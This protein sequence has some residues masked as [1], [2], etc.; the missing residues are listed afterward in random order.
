MRDTAFRC[1]CG[2]AGWGGMLRPPP[3]RHQASAALSSAGRPGPRRR[4]APHR[5]VLHRASAR[6]T[7]WRGSRPGSGRHADGEL[8]GD[9]R[10]GL[11]PPA[12]LGPAV[13]VTF[14]VDAG[15]VLLRRPTGRIDVVRVLKPPRS[16]RVLTRLARSSRESGLQGAHSCACCVVPFYCR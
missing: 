2:I 12:G 14:V 16:R 9:R 3:A 1:P 7:C 5:E 6:G 8:D 13:K 15:T 4:L 10:L 11:P